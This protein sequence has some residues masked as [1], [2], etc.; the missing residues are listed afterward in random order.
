[1]VDI[2]NA[3]SPTL[4]QHLSAG[5]QATG[6]KLTGNKTY[7]EYHRLLADLRVRRPLQS[8]P[9][10]AASVLGLDWDMTQHNPWLARPHPLRKLAGA[11]LGRARRVLGRGK[12]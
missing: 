1:M 12:K 7:N 3:L 5:A 4:L 6:R 11:V 9:T 2:W 8:W 10:D